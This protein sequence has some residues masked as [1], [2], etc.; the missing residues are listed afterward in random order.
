MSNIVKSDKELIERYQDGDVHSFELLIGR[1]QKQ[2]YSYILTLVKDKQLADDVFQDT[3]VKVI[4]TIKSKGYKDDGRFVQ[5]AMRIA[6]NLVIDHFRKE[7]RIPTVE[8][9]SEDYNYID[10]VPITDHSVEQ[11]MIVDQVHSD[12]HRMIAFLPDE[13]REVLRMR[14]FDDMSFKDIA[15]ITNVSINTALGRMRYALIN[16]RKM[17]VA[18]NMTLTY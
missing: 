15:D 10:N 1:Y 12:L 3:F 17:M 11:G 5:F 18:N 6:H 9:S 14:I 16:L 7:N 2:V 8:S 4:Q 13:Q